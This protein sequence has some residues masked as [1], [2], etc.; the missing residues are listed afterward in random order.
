MATQPTTT[1]QA[2]ETLAQVSERTG[3]GSRTIRRYVA[4]GKLVAYRAGRN[5]RFK[6]QDVDAMFTPTTGF[7]GDRA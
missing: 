1:S 3:L 5:L 7:G 4:E 6:P 2:Y